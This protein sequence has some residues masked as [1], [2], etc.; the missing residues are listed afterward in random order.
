MSDERTTERKLQQ[1]REQI[2]HENHKAL[3]RAKIGIGVRAA[4]ILFVMAYMTWL[5]GAVAQ[6]DAPA[7]THMAASSLEER[8]PQFRSDLQGYAIDMTPELTDHARDAFVEIPVRVRETIEQPLL[9]KSDDLIAGVEADVDAAIA[10]V[11]EEQLALMA[12]EVSEGTPEEQLDAL[13]LGISDLFRDTMIQALD[14]LYIEY[15]REVEDL[16]AHLDHLLRDEGLTPTEK[17]DRQ[18][19][20][21][22]MVL[23]Y[24]HKITDPGALVAGLEHGFQGRRSR[25]PKRGQLTG[26]DRR[27]VRPGP[28]GDLRRGLF[29]GAREPLDATMRAARTLHGAPADPSSRLPRKDAHGRHVGHV[30]AA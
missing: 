10:T 1:L 4:L 24:R 7:L 2:E 15:S 20:E 14:E 19:I 28:D 21:I 17:I 9:D 16:N 30:I 25:R 23:V 29:G 26:R 8:I 22:W 5:S 18:L 27:P 6:L 13:I 12:A 3:L 11:V